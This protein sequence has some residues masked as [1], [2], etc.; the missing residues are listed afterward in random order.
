MTTISAVIV[1]YNPTLK[2]PDTA[3]FQLFTSDHLF[4]QYDFKFKNMFFFETFEMVSW[5]EKV[6]RFFCRVYYSLITFLENNFALRRNRKNRLRFSML[7]LKRLISHISF[8]FFLV[9]NAG[10]GRLCH[11]NS[12]LPVLLLCF[13]KYELTKR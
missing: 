13:E 1:L 6:S 12:C 2:L 7:I 4:E 8:F 10:N 3:E 11:F 5:F 9:C